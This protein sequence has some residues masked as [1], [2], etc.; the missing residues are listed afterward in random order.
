[1]WRF[2]GEGVYDSQ[3]KIEAVLEAGVTLFDTADIYGPKE[4][5]GF[6]QAE[7]ALGE[8]FAAAPRLRDS[9]V[10]ATKGGIIPG[11][12]YDSSASYLAA[13][14]DGSLKRLN[15]ERI[16]L[17]QIHRPD[18]LTH[19]AE[20][21]RV[22]ED[23][24][25]AGKISSVGVSNYTVSQTSNLMAC[26]DLPVAS[27]QP[28]FS[29][30]HLDPLYDGIL[31]QAIMHNMAVLAWSPLG[32]GKLAQPTTDREKH[33][34]EIIDRKASETG[35]SS[36]AAAYS[37]IMAHPARP[38]PIVGS[39]TLARIAEIPDAYLPRWTRQEWYSVLVA[40]TGKPLP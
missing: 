4:K 18:I 23:A 1:M 34:V 19:P 36:S 30:L 40:A 13:A 21:A 17:W 25:R 32:G 10:L 27:H 22:L 31:D 6:G 9:I 11:V 37:W 7:R 26:L 3:K 15:V 16:D 38:I 35:V 8:V 12:P 33:V 24:H 29:A 5:G 20:V 2:G 14:I 39:Q 28:E